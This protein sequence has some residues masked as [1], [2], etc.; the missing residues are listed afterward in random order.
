M[1]GGKAINPQKG[2]STER[3]EGVVRCTT[4]FTSGNENHQHTEAYGVM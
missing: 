1:G 2:W 4:S 3:E